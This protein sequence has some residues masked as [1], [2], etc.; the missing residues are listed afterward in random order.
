MAYKRNNKG[1]TKKKEGGGRI[2]KPTSS[3]GKKMTLINKRSE[4]KQTKKIRTNLPGDPRCR[5]IYI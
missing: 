1:T 3:S 2:R 5:Y 4:G